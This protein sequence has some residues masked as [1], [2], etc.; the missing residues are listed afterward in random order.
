MPLAL[1]ASKEKPF[2]SLDVLKQ[3]LK[4]WLENTVVEEHKVRR[5]LSLNPDGTYALLLSSGVVRRLKGLD[6]SYPTDV[7]KLK[8]LAKLYQAVN[9]NYYHL[10]MD[11]LGRIADKLQKKGYPE[12]IKLFELLDEEPGEKCLNKRVMI[13]HAGLQKEFVIIEEGKLRYMIEDS[14]LEEELENADLLINMVG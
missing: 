4:L 7:E 6:A 11:E 8:K 2:K 10:I 14:K 12:K 5:R 1:C 9:E 13:A 3:A